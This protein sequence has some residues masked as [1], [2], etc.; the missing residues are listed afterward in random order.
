MSHWVEQICQYGAI[1]QYSAERFKHTHQPTSR[2][3]GTPPITIPTTCWKYS[4]LSVA[5]CASKSESSISKPSLSIRRTALLPAQ[6]SPPVFICQ[7][8]WALSHMRNPNSKDP[9]AAQI[10][11]ILTLWSKT[12]EHYSTLC[13]MQYTMWQYTMALGGLSNVWAIT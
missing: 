1:Q 5:F 12:S 13:K 7:L 11:I 10:E 4:S 3:I 2:M 6:C 9:K 8:P